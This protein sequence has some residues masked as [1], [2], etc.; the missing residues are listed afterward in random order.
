MS[1]LRRW[2]HRAW[3][4]AIIVAGVAT[5][6]AVREAAPTAEEVTAPFVRPAESN[7]P[8]HLHGFEV[9]VA[10]VEGA[11][12]VNAA[13]YT[14]PSNGVW[15]V[16][17]SRLH[18]A[19]EPTALRYAALYDAAG[20]EYRA[21]TRFQQDVLEL[22]VEPGVDVVGQLAFELPTDAALPLELRV[23]RNRDTRLDVVAALALD[24][25]TDDLAAWASDHE[26]ILI[27]DREVAP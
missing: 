10:D 18:A 27:G 22:P 6:T 19:T 7:A 4:T 9:T 17:T 26:P 1:S 15:V 14:R 23:A 2:G 5:A 16:V 13:P 25:T 8:G 21:S 24:V 12:S 20:N 3:Q 11:K